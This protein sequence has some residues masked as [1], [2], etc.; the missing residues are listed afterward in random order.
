MQRQELDGEAIK[1]NLKAANPYFYE[2]FEKEDR[3][4]LFHSQPPTTQELDQFL[5]DL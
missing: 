4:T 3:T 5:S 2:F 1:N